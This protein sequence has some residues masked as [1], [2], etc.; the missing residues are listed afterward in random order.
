MIVSKVAVVQNEG[1]Q[2]SGYCQLMD[3]PDV[4]NM[5]KNLVA[6]DFLGVYQ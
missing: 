2:M 1:L 6:H 5:T 4:N 3:P